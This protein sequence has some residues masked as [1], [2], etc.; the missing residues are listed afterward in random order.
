M[1]DTTDRVTIEDDATTA[2]PE[3]PFGRFAN[4]KPRKSPPKGSKP[5]S[6]GGRRTAAAPKPPRAKSSKAPNFTKMLTGAFGGLGAVVSAA[7]F[8]RRSRTVVADGMAVQMAA[9][10]LA[11][12]FNEIAQVSPALQRILTQAGP[13]LPFANLAYAL[14]ELGAQIAANHG[15]Q[16]PGFEVYNPD[17][18]IQA[19]EHQARQ[20]A[21]EQQPTGGGQSGPTPADMPQQ[22]P[23][24]DHQ[25][26]AAGM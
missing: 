24:H 15:K 19:A 23:Q 12:G 8:R 11:E 14:L 5:S 16:L 25:F 4:G 17:D 21:A 13:A 10:P 26:A 1:T 20:A 3:A 7:G 9:K 22:Q 18:L 2:D 6:G